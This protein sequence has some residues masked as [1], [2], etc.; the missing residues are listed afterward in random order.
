MIIDA[1]CH[2]WPDALAAR[3]LSARPAGLDPVGNGTL[4]GLRRTMDAAG[5]DMA[6]T[7][8]IANVPQHVERTN[9]FVGAV[10]RSRFIPFGTVHPGLSLD[11]NLMSLRDNGI[12]AVK[13]HP[14]FQSLPLDGLEVVEVLS[15]LATEGVTVLTHVGQG[16]DAAATDRGSPLR[17]RSLSEQVPDLKLIACHFGGYHRLEEARREVMGSSVVLETSW[18]PSL[19][20]LP[21]DLVRGLIEEHGAGRFVYGSDWPMADPAT[22]IAAIRSLDLSPEDE[23]AVLGGTL[24]AL[25][26]VT[27]TAT[28]AG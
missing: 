5:I 2:V 6:C 13:L 17:L 22:E 20:E 14:N 27:P 24:A 26:D 7:L 8:A 4:D 10:D 1:H 19:A 9:E 28:A 3:V 25:L 15:A 12:R 11:R 21:G 23:R 16:N 18:P